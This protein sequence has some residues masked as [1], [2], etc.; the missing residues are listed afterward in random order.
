V[1]ETVEEV[2][3]SDTAPKGK[4]G[5]A[6]PSIGAGGGGGGGGGGFAGALAQA[7]KNMNPL[8]ALGR[9]M[10]NLAASDGS[11]ESMYRV[12]DT[13][14]DETRRAIAESMQA[15]RNNRNPPKA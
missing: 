11:P 6:S 8:T 7:A 10:Q 4:D 12:P 2:Y 5:D 3:Q 15:M 9:T 1:T 13:G 14:I